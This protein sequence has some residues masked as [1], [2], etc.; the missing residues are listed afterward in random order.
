MDL[1]KQLVKY[2]LEGVAVALAAF[3]IPR[4]NMNIMEIAVIVLTA[5]ATFALL[6]VFSPSIAESA[7][8][9]SGFGIGL[10]LI[11]GYDDE[12]DYSDS[13]DEEPEG[14]DEGEGFVTIR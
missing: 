9:G 13:E 11:E 12:D 3:Y 1:K 4:R 8:K 14:I 10:N 7:R 5:T 2:I 6:D